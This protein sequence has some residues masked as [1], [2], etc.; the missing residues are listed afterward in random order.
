[1][2][3]LHRLESLAAGSLPA[4]ERRRAVVVFND[5]AAPY[6]RDARVDE[7]VAA[8]AAQ[9]PEAV[10]VVYGDRVLRYGELNSRA[11]QLAATL[12]AAGV[13]PGALVAT[14]L[15]RSTELVV[16]LLGILKT[17]AAYLPLDVDH[18]P[19]WVAGVL[20]AAGARVVVTTAS[21]RG[22]LRDG[23]GVEVV[24][25]D[26]EW[27]RA[28]GS[29]G[30]GV[31]EAL[32]AGDEV[33]PGDGR[34]VALVIYTSGST[35][36]P[37]GVA[38][39]H[40]AI[41]RMVVNS[42]YL[43]LGPDDCVGQASNCA[44]DA[45]TFEIWGTLIN[46]ARLVGLS[47]ETVLAPPALSRTLRTEGITVLFLTTALFNQVAQQ[48]PCC[49][50]G[51][52]TLLVGGEAL[53]PHW[54][55]EVLKH[56]PP[57]RFLNVYGP[58]ENTTFTS[59]HVIESLSTETST[60][61]IGGPISNTQMYVLDRDLRPAPIGVPGEL[62]TGGAG[63]A[64]GYWARPDLTA[65][66][67][68][69]NPFGE[70]GG[71]L[72][73]T[74]DLTRYLADGSIEFL[75]RIDQQVKIRGFRI[76]PAEVE[77]VLQR[78]PAVREAVVLVGAGPSG[79]K[80]LIAYT[81]CDGRSSSIVEESKK[82]LKRFAQEQLPPYMVPS[83]FVPLTSM[84]LNRNGKVDRVALAEMNLELE[85]EPI[86]AAQSDL[87]ARIA[88]VWQQVLRL[89]HVGATENFFDVGG[90]SILSIVVVA[91]LNQRGIRTTPKALFEHQTIRALAEVVEVIDGSTP[92]SA[93]DEPVSGRVPLAPIQRFFFDQRLDEPQHW[94]Q[95]VLLRAQELD[96]PA[97]SDA[98]QALTDHHDALRLRFERRD[99]GWAQENAGRGEPVSL[100]VID[101]AE[102]GV[103]RLEM[104]ATRVQASLDL[105][106]G[107][108]FKA[109]LFR[110]GEAGDRLLLAAHHLVVDLVSWRILVE[111][112]ERA[113]EQRLSGRAIELP[114]KTCSYTRWAAA[115]A[116][117]A[118]TIGP[119]TLAYWTEVVGRAATDLP[120]DG[121]AA[122]GV[123][124]DTWGTTERVVSSLDAEATRELQITARQACRM[125]TNEFL[126]AAM[127]R[128]LGKWTG[129]S[130][131]LVYLEGHGRDAL[132]DKWDLGRTIGW[133][134]TLYPHP[135]AT[136]IELNAAEHL[137]RVKEDLRRV[138]DRGA[139]YGALRWI[140]RVDGL[141][142]DPEPLLS[143][144]YRGQVDGV[145]DGP[146]FRPAPESPGRTIDPGAPRMVPINVEAKIADGRLQV[147]WYYGRNRYRRDTIACL[148]DGF[149]DAVRELTRSSAAAA[150][151]ARTASDYPLVRLRESEVRT[152]PAGVEDVWPL[153]RIQHGVLFHALYEPDLPL[154]SNQL[155]FKL[156]GALQPQ[157]FERAWQRIIESHAVL[158]STFRWQGF[159]EPI[160]LV[161]RSARVDVRCEDL[162]GLGENEQQQHIT[163]VCNQDWQRPYE[164]DRGPLMRLALFTLAP[165]CHHVLWSFHHILLD[166][167]S[168]AN[169]LGELFASYQALVEGSEPPPTLARPYSD[170]L[171]WL[172]RQDRGAAREFWRGQL[173]D[174]TRPT[175]VPRTRAWRGRQRDSAEVERSLSATSSD[176]LANLA[177]RERVTL[178]SVAHAT[179]AVVLCLTSGQ[180]DVVFGA[181][182]SG[183]P[184][185]LP[186]I[187]HMVGPFINAVPVRVRVDEDALFVDVVHQ[188][189]AR[190]LSARA[191]EHSLLA[192]V[193]QAS[194]VSPG[195]NLFDSLVTY[196]NYPGHPRRR[197]PGGIRVSGMRSREST[198][199]DLVLVVTPGETLRLRLC[200]DPSVLESA[201][202]E[203]LARSIEMVMTR[204]AEHPRAP[205]SDLGISPALLS[206]A[207]AT[208]RID[209]EE[210]DDV[211]D[212]RPRAR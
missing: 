82:E 61:P 87:E 118:E 154:Y 120:A 200:Y 51:L 206:S 176:A 137:G 2:T 48:D 70:P 64:D 55:R 158:R 207:F 134:T 45:A 199:Y 103:W 152:L 58:A 196:E 59:F 138:P 34:C 22:R 6:P 202:A 90:D 170:Y 73:R 100:E 39:P 163:C 149:L 124:D 185:D 210:L 107:P 111:D 26:A 27:E 140:R 97:L 139:S 113:Y 17:G 33:K 146:R 60:V 25:L 186:D 14:W 94:N 181:T 178:S 155:H 1:M 127:G 164:L 115:W 101:L 83:V 96:E 40:R 31:G 77:A 28:A 20:E 117:Y 57:K 109:A 65:D 68:M 194:G 157:L 182:V 76:E 171:A 165:D 75:G 84:P 63:L 173:F 204:V 144:N 184:A 110:L 53:N 9:R 162:S 102:S 12:R 36:Q 135:L 21:V 209:E 159:Q 174:F 114:A 86:V 18:P 179:W 3:T 191:Y 49:F 168:V 24:S 62:W 166:G 5:T 88:D 195:Q 42:N 8:Q 105:A 147:S 119:E 99:V 30:P 78:H 142:G 13:K 175:P 95:A 201:T 150:I 148:A 132:G 79:G 37:K 197:A 44:F 81:V 177:R 188:V 52:R 122:D 208:M 85:R 23:S 46:G 66:R 72:Y 41:T 212:V 172:A 93:G 74:G 189:N 126:L 123:A 160:Q 35:G 7:L 187:E 89:D 15:E 54:V 130:E 71:R 4:D 112:L 32:R 192:E 156:E 167:W 190:L 50:A 69:P 128:A 56:G 106:H 169:V 92:A 183:R 141:L 205:I 125:E 180:H 143:F 133:F 19:E 129:R 116:T 121:V 161:M 43:Q 67:F 211:L 203:H 136:A 104:E 91:R 38:V 131:V 153:G 145:A 193:Q 108:V 29:E 10:A 11:A 198:H 16:A 151:P 98:L 47:R 80:R